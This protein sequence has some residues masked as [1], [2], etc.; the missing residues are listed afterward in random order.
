MLPKMSPGSPG[1]KTLC[2]M[3]G[4]ILTL[5]FQIVKKKDEELQKLDDKM[6]K[7][8]MLSNVGTSG[9]VLKSKGVVIAKKPVA[10]KPPPPP[11]PMDELRKFFLC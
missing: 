3:C 6:K 9:P 10:P 4:F 7:V 11:P 5:F 1:I 2:Q 8:V